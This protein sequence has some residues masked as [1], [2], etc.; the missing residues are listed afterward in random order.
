M[1][2]APLAFILASAAALPWQAAR[3]APPSGNSSTVRITLAQILVSRDVQANLNRIRDAIAI[4]ERDKADWIL[5]PEGALSGYTSEFDQSAVVAAFDEVRQLCKKSNV[6]GL[7]G[8]SWKENAQTFNQV[9][10]VDRDGQLA[11][12]CAKTCLTYDEARTFTSGDSVAPHLIDG[13]SAGILICN[14]MWVTPG[15]TDGPDPH[16]S[17]QLAK[18]GAG[19]IL[20]SVNSGSNQNFRGY[21]E[22]NLKIRSAEACC[23]IVVV[24]AAQ[25]AEINCTS[26][27]VDGFHYIAELPRV[28]EHVQTVEVKLRVKKD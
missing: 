24:N 3:A 2:R 21:H 19:L 4:A 9:R 12:A 10:I 16:L 28:G 11:A 26:G 22:E 27:V 23:P 5:F 18:A 25:R 6:I 1:L 20:H 15:F 14:D 7:I 17:R 13:I 8:T